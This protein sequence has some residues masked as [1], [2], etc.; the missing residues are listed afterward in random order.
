MDTFNR[1]TREDL[2][3]ARELFL[4]AIELDPKYA[5]P[6]SKIAWTH[7]CDVNLGWSH[8]SEQSFSQALEYAKRAVACDDEEPWGYWAMAGYYLFCTQDH[9]RATAAYERALAINPNDADVL[10]DFG[11]CLSY[12]GRPKEAVEVVRRAMRLNPHYPEYW[13]MQFGPILFDAR[14]YEESIATLESLRSVDTT[15]VQLYL[16]ASYA[17][18]TR[19]D[20]AHKAV[21]RV[22]DLDPKMTIARCTSPEFSP[23]KDP[24]DLEHFRRNVREAGLPK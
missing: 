17:A 24:D 7:I 2:E 16:A 22:L 13:V 9:N 21:N 4:R 15:S 10:N 19:S 6:Y 5:K 18:L 8:N 1:F 11:Q 14:Q 23:Y 3:R 20:K 12:A